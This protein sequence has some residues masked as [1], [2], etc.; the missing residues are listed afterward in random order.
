MATSIKTPADAGKAYAN[1]AYAAMPANMRAGL[2]APSLAS[3]SEFSA[4]LFKFPGRADAF[5]SS[6][7]QRIGDYRVKAAGA[8][9]KL[10]SK[11]RGN[12]GAGGV[13]MEVYVDLQ[14]IRDW[15]INN[16]YV[17]E[18]LT[19]F[20]PQNVHP[21]YYESNFY[22]QT[23]PMS[24]SPEKEKFAFSSWDELFNMVNRRFD[25]LYNGIKNAEFKKSVEI[26]N[27]AVEKGY[28]KCVKINDFT[29]ATQD[30]INANYVTTREN[31]LNMEVQSTDYN[32]A[33]LYNL[34]EIFD[35]DVY[36]L[37]KV[38]AASS[39]NLAYAF[40][41][42]NADF[43]GQVI[44]LPNFAGAEKDGLQMFACA[45]DWFFIMDNFRTLTHGYNFL[46]LTHSYAYTVSS[47]YSFALYANAVAYTTKLKTID[48]VTVIA[49]QTAQ[50]G[51]GTEIKVHVSASGE[52]LYWA[53]CDYSITGQNSKNTYITP[54]GVLYVDTNETASTITVT[55]TSRQD[56]TKTNSAAVT[57]TT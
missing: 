31:A 56:P 13:A 37:N 42:E 55:A 46:N 39:V 24:V 35:Q 20:K 22:K 32:F 15:D 2:P 51:N 3:A 9:N 26:I 52:G 50:K 34:S 8:K 53:A 14:A 29:T 4:A 30:E 48:S 25:A 43:L 57:V 17:G 5:Y 54:Y 10:E 18:V 44:S 23:V 12:M 6:L 7:F 47:I 21:F 40:H 38:N 28:I 33:G 45:K 49:S 16:D 27:E 19:T 1:I 11:K 41:R 36:V